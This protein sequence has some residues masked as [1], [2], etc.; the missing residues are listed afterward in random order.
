M[1]S[2][3]KPGRKVV[4]RARLKAKKEALERGACSAERVFKFEIQSDGCLL[5]EMLD[6]EEYRRKIARG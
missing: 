5:R 3:G 4:A 6:P 2:K 1:R